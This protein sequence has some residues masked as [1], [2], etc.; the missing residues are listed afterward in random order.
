MSMSETP[1]YIYTHYTDIGHESQVNA[2][3]IYIYLVKMSKHISGKQIHN[4]R[5]SLMKKKLRQSLKKSP[6]SIVDSNAK[7]KLS[8]D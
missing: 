3:Y 4:N 5:T 2:I 1:S 6:N 7:S 8:L